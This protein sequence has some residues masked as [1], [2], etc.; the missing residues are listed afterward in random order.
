MLSRVRRTGAA[1]IDMPVAKPSSRD[2]GAKSALRP[3]VWV[4]SFKSADAL[5][6]PAKLHLSGYQIELPGRT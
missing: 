3:D 2:L 4:V 6:A 1:R 5:I